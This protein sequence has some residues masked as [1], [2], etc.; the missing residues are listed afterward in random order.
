MVIVVVKFLPGL[1]IDCCDSQFSNIKA[2]RRAILESHP[3]DIA[4]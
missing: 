1:R 3:A 4:T 2:V